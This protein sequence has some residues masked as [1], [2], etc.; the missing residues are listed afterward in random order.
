MNGLGEQV[1]L[2]YIAGLGLF[3]YFTTFKRVF[4]RISYTA[5]RDIKL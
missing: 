2:R 3:A 5:G 4:V 1:D